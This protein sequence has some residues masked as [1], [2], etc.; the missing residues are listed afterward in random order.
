MQQAG[1]ASMLNSALLVFAI[2]CLGGA[3]KRNGPIRV[4]PPIRVTPSR[5]NV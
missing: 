2:A 4:A 1:M 3:A 5:S